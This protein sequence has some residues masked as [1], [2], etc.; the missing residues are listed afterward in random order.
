MTG[1]LKPDR[2]RALVRL[3]QAGLILSAS[4]VLGGLGV[5]SRGRWG[6]SRRPREI[7]DRRVAP[8]SRF[9]PLAVAKG[10]DPARVVQAALAAVGG[11]ERFIRPGETVLLKPNMGWDRTPEQGANTHPAVV[12]EV[13]RLCRAAGAKRVIVA[14]V[15]INDS[16]RCAARSGIQAAALAAG[17][18]VALPPAAAFTEAALNGA[19]L[20]RWEVLAVLFEADKLVN[21]PVVKDHSL[22]RMTCGFKN[23]YGLLG[24]TRGR[25]HQEINQCIADLATAIRPTL[26]VV[27]ATR[28][29]VRGG[30]TGGRLDQVVKMDSVAAG[31]DPVAL[32]AWSATLLDLDPRTI[33]YIGIVE[34][35][36]LGSMAP[37]LAP[38]EAIHVGG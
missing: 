23:W 36:G 6:R 19:V 27:D 12:A 14:D 20:S 31:T 32:E 24:G 17:A 26:T 34:K 5:F 30:P 15:P 28:V 37:G 7:R 10:E 33:P 25:L 38:I 21:L 29:M 16:A 35:R 8:D 13:A 3:G 9:P 4:A 18:E 22:S 2:R 11:I 1:P